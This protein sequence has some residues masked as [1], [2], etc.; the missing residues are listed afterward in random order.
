[1]DYYPEVDEFITILREPF[2]IAVSNY[3]FVKKRGEE[4]FR[5]GK[6]HRI[7][8]RFKD[9]NDYLLGSPQSWLLNYMPYEITMDNYEEIFE[10]HFVY[11][12]IAEYLQASVDVL[13]DKLGFPS[14]EVERRNIAERDEEV[15][16]EVKQE[17]INNNQLEYAIYEWAL[18]NYNQ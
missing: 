8:E 16:E 9:V 2:E 14:V 18:R 7:E 12:G 4:S 5:A 11:V 3:F 13:A 1:M 15:S 17:F 6:P 10:K